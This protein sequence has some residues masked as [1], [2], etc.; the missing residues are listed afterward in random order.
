M[1]VGD[2]YQNTSHRSLIIQILSCDDPT[3]PRA[4]CISPS[5]GRYS[6]WNKV[7][8]VVDFVVFIEEC[9]EFIGNFAKQDSF[10]Q[11]YNLLNG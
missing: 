4:I 3:A 10:E 6:I 2:R 5:Q 8:M 7:G 11:L 9:W 1:K